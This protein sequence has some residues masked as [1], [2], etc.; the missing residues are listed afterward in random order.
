MQRSKQ[1]TMKAI[2]EFS[3]K[4]LFGIEKSQNRNPEDIPI[5]F[6]SQKY[7]STSHYAKLVLKNYLFLLEKNPNS[8]LSKQDLERTKEHHSVD[9][10]IDCQ[11]C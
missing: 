5:V 11:Y 4:T 3:V 10:L 6:L 2:A 9:G 1:K 7:D 8:N